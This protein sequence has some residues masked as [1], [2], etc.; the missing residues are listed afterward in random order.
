MSTILIIIQ[1]ILDHDQRPLTNVKI[2]GKALTFGIRTAG[3]IEEADAQRAGKGNDVA[4]LTWRDLTEFQADNYQALWK[5][6]KCCD[7]VN[8]GA[9]QDPVTNDCVCKDIVDY[10]TVARCSLKTVRPCINKPHHGTFH[11]CKN[12]AFSR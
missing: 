1:K 11:L 6:L 8:W 7:K 5:E 10:P 12:L 4:Q 3:C 2:L 9:T